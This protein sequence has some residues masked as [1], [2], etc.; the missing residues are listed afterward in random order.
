M[1]RDPQHLDAGALVILLVHSLNRPSETLPAR[2]RL[3]DE[4]ERIA[5]RVVG[6]VVRGEGR[7]GLDEDCVVGVGGG[8]ACCGANEK[9]KRTCERWET[10][11]KGRRQ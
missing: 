10:V 6:R 7:R 1:S 11:S 5:K 4:T 2:R 9:W 3:V 8:V